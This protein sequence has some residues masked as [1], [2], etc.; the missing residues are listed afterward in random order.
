[1]S[2]LYIEGEQTMDNM[3]HIDY[4]AV[5]GGRGNIPKICPMNS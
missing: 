1:M 5:R 2:R 3:M 4:D